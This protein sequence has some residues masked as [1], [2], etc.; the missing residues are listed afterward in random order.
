[1]T[2][3]TSSSEWAGDSG[4]EST[5]APASS[6]HRQRRRRVRRAEVREVVHGQEVQAR[7]DALLTERLG[8]GVAVGARALAGDPHD[9]D[10]QPCTPAAPSLKP[11]GVM[12]AR[13]ARP[14]A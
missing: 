11:S 4:S 13:P 2:S 9:V 7:A 6:G 10:G 1:M 5:S 3:S 8:V 14:S 12:P